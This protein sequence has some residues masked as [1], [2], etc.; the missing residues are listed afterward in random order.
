MGSNVEPGEDG[1]VND[2]GIGKSR[3][4]EVRLSTIGWVVGV[5]AIAIVIGAA[6]FQY[7]KSTGED[8]GAARQ[9]GTAAGQRAGAAKGAA[10]GYAL[11]FKKGREA[12]FKR[13][14]PKP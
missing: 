4:I 13:I 14:Y 2:P 1:T 10:Q 9:E 3:S 5:L 6:A 8:L 11:G 12:G 7:G